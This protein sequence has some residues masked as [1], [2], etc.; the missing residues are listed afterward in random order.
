VVVGTQN[1]TPGIPTGGSGGVQTILT[2][3]GQVV[4]ANSQGAFVV[5]GVTASTNPQGNVA[6]GTQTFTPGVTRV[7]G[8]GAT[9]TS[10]AIG[11]AIIS[12][13]GFGSSTASSSASG[14]SAPQ[15]GGGERVVVVLKYWTV[16]VTIGWGV[17]LSL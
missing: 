10:A 12:I 6:V 9:T 15:S 16:V 5:S 11:G 7:G 13:G 3:N 1:Y 2:I 17:W 4:T 14:T 8:G